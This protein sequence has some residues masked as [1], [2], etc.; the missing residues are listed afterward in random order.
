MFV[1]S[2]DVCATRCGS[3]CLLRALVTLCPWRAVS[4]VAGCFMGALAA[5]TTLV[6]LYSG[7]AGRDVQVGGKGRRG[8]GF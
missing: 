7:S 4:Q 5:L 2:Q 1:L 8:R 3:A 6:D